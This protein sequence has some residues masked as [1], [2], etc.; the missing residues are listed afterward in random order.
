MHIFR[1]DRSRISRYPSCRTH[2]ASRKGGDSKRNESD[3]AVLQE[4]LAGFEATVNKILD[5]QCELEERQSKLEQHLAATLSG[6][7]GRS[8]RYDRP[9]Q[10]VRRNGRG[11]RHASQEQS[12]LARAVVDA[13]LFAAR[14]A[15]EAVGDWT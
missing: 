2:S 10:P 13:K 3:E 4:A 6:A 5:R 11:G 7:F 12:G 8:G 9:P 15:S 1:H 14:L